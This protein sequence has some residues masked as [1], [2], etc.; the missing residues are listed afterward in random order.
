MR[1][2][3]VIA[4]VFLLSGIVVIMQIHVNNRDPR[5]D[6]KGNIIDAHDGALEFFEGRFYWYGTAYGETDGFS[7]QNT[8]QVYS[9]SDLSHWTHHGNIL[10]DCPA[11]VYYRPY[12]KYCPTTKLYVLWWNW[13]PTL[14]NGQYG[15]ATSEQPEGPFRIVHEHVSVRHEK[16]GDFGLFVD[17]DSAGYL[18]YTSIEK[19][20]AI[21]IERLDSDFCSSTKEGSPFLSDESEACSLF[22]RGETYYALFDSTCCFCP[23]GSGAKVFI[24]DSP[25]G[26]YTFRGN[27]NRHTTPCG[28]VPIINAQQTHVARFP[29]PGGDIYVWTGDRWGSRLDGI[30]GHDFQFWSEPLRF[31]GD[32]SIETLRWANQWS[33]DL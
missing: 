31:R 24:A 3:R 30:K 17:N 25:L 26:P 32:G 4:G 15:V 23:Q 6:E 12:V 7:S 33:Y 16:P 14:W 11:G 20:H 8:F 5:L 1:D 18:I 9:S 2:S 28:D 19:N 29:A 22:R 27:M 10:P 21:S 13:Y